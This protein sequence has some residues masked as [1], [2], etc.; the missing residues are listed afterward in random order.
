[1]GRDFCDSELVSSLLVEFFIQFNRK[2]RRTFLLVQLMKSAGCQIKMF[3]CIWRSRP[4][5]LLATLPC[6]LALIW[7]GDHKQLWQWKF[8]FWKS[9]NLIKGNV[10]SIIC[11][12]P[13]FLSNRIGS[14]RPGE[15][16]MM[17]IPIQILVSFF[18]STWL[19]IFWNNQS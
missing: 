19:V 1:M 16:S 6:K 15:F 13:K 8:Y 2:K 7:W 10:S 5:N 4:R 9:A 11:C 14:A 3:S 17:K 18:C 12:N